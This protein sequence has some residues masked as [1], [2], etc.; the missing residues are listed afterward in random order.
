MAWASRLCDARLSGSGR[1]L[2]RG[3]LA[4][5]FPRLLVLGGAGKAKRTLENDS[6]S[7]EAAGERMAVPTGETLA[8]QGRGGL[9]PSRGNRVHRC[10]VLRSLR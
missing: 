6:R 9:C 5:R 3:R 1:F 4:W 7:E 10:L 8:F 2:V